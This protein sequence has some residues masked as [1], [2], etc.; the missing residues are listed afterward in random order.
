M[1]HYQ[2][3]DAALQSVSVRLALGLINSRLGFSYNSAQE[4][5]DKQALLDTYVNHLLQLELVQADYRMP[6]KYSGIKFDEKTGK[7]KKGYI[8]TTE[9]GNLLLRYIDLMNSDEMDIGENG[10]KLG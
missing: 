8:Q 6:D 3:Q 4:E 7:L 9:I 1:E 10:T 2:T 5:I